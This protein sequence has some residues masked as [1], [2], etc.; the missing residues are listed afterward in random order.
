MTTIAIILGPIFAVIITLFYQRYKEKRDFKHHIF[1]DLM[2][3]RKS[4][5]ISQEIVRELNLIDVG[6]SNNPK[7]LSLWHDYYQMLHQKADDRLYKLQEQKFVELLSEIAHDLGYK[8]LQQVDIDK[9][10][11]PM[12]HVNQFEYNVKLQAELL[13][14]LENTSKFETE[15]KE[16]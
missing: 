1:Y 2:S 5:P 4:F 15:K 14:V 10:Y 3:Q 13:R 7:V 8:N 16:S 9:F 12:A 6:F 11:T